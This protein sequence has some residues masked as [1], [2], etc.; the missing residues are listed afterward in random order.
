[1]GFPECILT[2][3]I[4]L[5]EFAISTCLLWGTQEIIISGSF[6]QTVAAKQMLNPCVFQT[7]EK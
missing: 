1:M 3:G 4:C 6:R 2:G 5:T 7:D